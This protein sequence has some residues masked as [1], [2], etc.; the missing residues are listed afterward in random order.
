MFHPHQAAHCLSFAID[1]IL[2]VSSYFFNLT[3]KG[4]NWVNFSG[5]LLPLEP[6]APH[7]RI[8]SSLLSGMKP[9]LGL[10]PEKK[11]I[12]ILV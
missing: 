4:L 1:F 6:H 8:F 12:F 5:A 2:F 3:P 7:L 9:S 10:F 11:S